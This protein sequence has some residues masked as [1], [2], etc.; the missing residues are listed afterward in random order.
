MFNLKDNI[1][2]QVVENIAL[3]KDV[4]EKLKINNN[5]LEKIK[6]INFRI[7]KGKTNFEQITRLV[8]HSVIQLS[9]LDLQLKDKEEA[10]NNISNDLINMIE[11]VS[12]VS[13][14]T[15]NISQEV[16]AAHTNMTDNVNGL[17]NNT[18]NLLDSAKKSENELVQI[19]GFSEDAMNYSINMKND[20]NNLINIIGNIEMVI[21]DISE[22]SDQTNLLA[23]N[24]SIEASRAGESG[25]G[26]AVVAEE[27]RH[28][29]DETKKLI[30]GMN[31]FLAAI[32]KASTKSTSSVE[33]TVNSL[34][35]I[36]ENLD[37]IVNI[38][39]QNRID[40]DNI[41]ET[42][43]VIASNSEEIN[44]SIDEVTQN[45]KVLD[46]NIS[47]LNSNINNLKEVSDG[48][49]YV[50]SPIKNIE[51]DLDKA[52]KLIGDMVDDKYYMT[53]NELLIETVKKAIEAHKL[54]ISTLKKII[55]TKIIVPLQ[56]DCHKCGFGHFYYSMV[57][58]NEK[59]LPIWE[60][61]E[62]NHTKLHNIGS[63]IINKIR[64]GEEL[65]EDVFI[66][67]EN[68]SKKVIEDFYKI[69]NISNQLSKDGINVYEK[70]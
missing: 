9:S 53:S 68:L 12:N 15:T 19:K 11:E 1:T 57:P 33:S 44:T 34:E 43:S 4:D 56:T 63:E 8:L 24:A 47:M 64:I 26:F 21:K 20:M 22:I 55:D 60:G 35:M 23:L 69:I 7:N 18:S 2:E 51:D 29:S 3:L 54:W 13:E 31:E 58:K 39:K 10:I 17:S 6:S 45:I 32:R 65:T 14:T 52:A 30:G 28:L 16:T 42:V 67:A 48:V 36:N 40:I 41:T 61:I 50:V 25:K 49:A 70:Q 46:N 27:I 38:Q 5:T 59:I 62:N 66:E 37:S